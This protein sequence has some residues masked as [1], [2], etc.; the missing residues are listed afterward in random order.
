[1]LS[2]LTI[3]KLTS[4][5]KYCIN[6]YAIVS[7][8]VEHKEP[9]YLLMLA[10]SYTNISCARF[11]DKKA[12]LVSH[13]LG[14]IFK[15]KSVRGK[16]MTQEVYYNIGRLY[17]QVGLFSQAVSFYKRALSSPPALPQYNLQCE[18]AYNLYLI[19]MSSGNK[20][21]AFH[22]LSTYLVV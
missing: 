16:P 14:W 18:I 20:K 1:M 19:Y 4:N 13:A 9:L 3:A 10:V 5:Y 11:M 6:E 21:L 7:R 2:T 8:S 17:H 12:Y 22:T 15:Y